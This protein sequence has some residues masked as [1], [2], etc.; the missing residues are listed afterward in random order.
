MTTKHRIFTVVVASV[1][2]LY[3]AKV[4]KKGRTK[5]EVD[6][7]ICWLTGGWLLLA[8]RYSVLGTRPK[9]SGI[10]KVAVPKPAS[11]FAGLWNNIAGNP[12][13]SA[14]Q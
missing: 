7:V 1:Y 14:R 11:W 8:Y 5:V 2:P 9:T 4:E 3:I 12:I 10:P 6:A 13:P